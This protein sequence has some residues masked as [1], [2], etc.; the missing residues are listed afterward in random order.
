MVVGVEGGDDHD[1]QGVCDV[2][3]GELPGRLHAVE[4]GHPDVEQADVGT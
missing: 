2:M 4:A 3:S 1:G